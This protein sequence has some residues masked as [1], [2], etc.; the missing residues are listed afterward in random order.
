M[1]TVDIGLRNY[2]AGKNAKEGFIKA[3][4]FLFRAE[5]A[6]QESTLVQDA[7][8]VLG[9]IMHTRNALATAMDALAVY[10]ATALQARA[11]QKPKGKAVKSNHA[12]A[13]AEAIVATAKASPAPVKA[14]AK[15]PPSKKA[16]K[17]A[18]K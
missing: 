10:E 4:Q 9:E 18:R 11:E 1:R 14:A 2:N 6:L 8:P 13:Q 7:E 16:V 5:A 15:A 3:T 17:K 12:V